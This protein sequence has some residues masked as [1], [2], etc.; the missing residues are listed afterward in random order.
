[1][2]WSKRGAR[3]LLQTRIKTL[4][5]EWGTVLKRWYPSLRNPEPHRSF[6][7]AYLAALEHD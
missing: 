6:V 4:N 5:R 2:Q 7:F 3:L 1:M